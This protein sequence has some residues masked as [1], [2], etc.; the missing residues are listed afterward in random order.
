MFFNERKASILPEAV[1]N[2][3]M[4]YLVF[5]SG[6]TL[7]VCLGISP[8]F[9]SSYNFRISAFQVALLKFPVCTAILGSIQH[10][11]QNSI[12]MSHSHLISQGRI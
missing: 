8:S 6:Y 12:R 10:P 7:V 5:F 3:P 1:V 9:L 4:S 11:N 2:G